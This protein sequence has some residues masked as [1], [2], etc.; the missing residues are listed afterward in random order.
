MSLVHRR[1]ISGKESGAV[2]P[3]E[4][5]F[6]AINVSKRGT[7]IA[8][9]IEL[10]GTSA[11]RRRGLLGRSKLDPE[12]GIYLVPCGWIHTFRMKFPI[13]VVFLGRDGRVL[14]VH[15]SLRPGRLSKIVLRARGALELSAGRIRATGTEVGDIIEFR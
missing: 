5:L 6:R 11:Q 1:D 2:D 7:I 9:R 8:R 13:D 10:A 14:S 15:H 12:E 4:P 3:P